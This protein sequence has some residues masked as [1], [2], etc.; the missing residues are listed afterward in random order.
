M[1]DAIVTPHGLKILDNIKKTEFIWGRDKKNVAHEI[2]SKIFEGIKGI[3][4]HAAK[5]L[6]SHLTEFLLSLAL[7]F[8]PTNY[9]FFLQNESTIIFPAHLA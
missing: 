7:A 3:N 5:V 6:F 8:F 4:F 9:L 1:V 2:W